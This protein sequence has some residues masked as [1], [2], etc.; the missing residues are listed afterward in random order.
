MLMLRSILIQRGSFF[1]DKFACKFASKAYLFLE[2]LFSIK[3]NSIYRNLYTHLFALKMKNKT[4]QNKKTANSPVSRISSSFVRSVSQDFSEWQ[5][6]LHLS[7]SEG[8]RQNASYPL[9]IFSSCSKKAFGKSSVRSW[10]KEKTV[11]KVRK[12]LNHYLF[13]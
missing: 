9:P 12:I 2:L 1:C 5:H 4:K 6:H 13:Q 8:R 10:S 3:F 7:R 11:A